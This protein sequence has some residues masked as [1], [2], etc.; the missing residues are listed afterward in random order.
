M[1]EIPCSRVLAEWSHPKTNCDRMRLAISQ[2]LNQ[3]LFYSLQTFQ[4]KELDVELLLVSQHL[5]NWDIILL[6][7]VSSKTNITTMK[8]VQDGS[9]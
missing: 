5:Q 2:D 7:D 1:R 9:V 4:L 6:G 8:I 3:A